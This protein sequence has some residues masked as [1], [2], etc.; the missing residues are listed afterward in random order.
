MDELVT[1]AIE[2]R[3]NRPDVRIVGLVAEADAPEAPALRATLPEESRDPNASVAVVV[4]R[5]SARDLLGDVIPGLLDWLPDDDGGARQKLPVI[6]AA[7]QGMRTE[8]I[9]YDLFD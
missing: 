8:L 7:R 6:H 5:E 3:R 4:T 1:K 9:E 2:I